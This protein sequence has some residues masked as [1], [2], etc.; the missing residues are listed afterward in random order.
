[1]VDPGRSRC[2]RGNLRRRAAC[3]G[4]VFSFVKRGMRKI[5][6][7]ANTAVLWLCCTT[8]GAQDLSL[9]KINTSLLE[10]DRP[11]ALELAIF[12][13]K[14]DGP[15]PT[16]VF[17]HGSVSNGNNP[18]EVTHTVTYAELAAFFNERGWLVIF[19][20]RRGRGK[21]EGHYAEGW[22]TEAGRY[23]CDPSVS[24]AGLEHAIQDINE[25]TQHLKSRADVDQNRMLIGGHSK[26]GILAM[27]FAAAQ[28]ERFVGVLNFVGG[29]VGERCE[30][31]DKINVSTFVKAAAFP[32][33]TLWLY[34]ERD[35]YYSIAHSQKSFAAFT[36]AGGKGV[37]HALTFGLLRN[38]HQIVRN[39]AI[40][41]EPMSL[42]LN[43]LNLCQEAVADAASNP[44]IER[45]CPGKPGHASHLK[46][47]P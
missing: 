7:L 9:Q 43:S 22:Q 20:Q 30:T 16:L 38:D 11:V 23:S 25:V 29:W 4:M 17:N 6:P 35:P 1:M 12:K 13:P 36:S 19:P 2:M 40:W 31:A 18:K 34:G 44:S 46:R 5:L 32:G 37:F 14:G 26:G 41:S 28:P 33:P 24:L 45:T 42:F 3:L 27:R 21:S 10:E 47:Y 39:R 15:F 8:A